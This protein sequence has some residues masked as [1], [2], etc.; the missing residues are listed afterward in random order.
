MVAECILQSDFSYS[1]FCFVL[2]EVCKSFATFQLVWKNSNVLFCRCR[3]I[4]YGI[5][6]NKLTNCHSLALIY[7]RMTVLIFSCRIRNSVV[8]P[9][10]SFVGWSQ[11]GSC[12]E[13]QFLTL[14]TRDQLKKKLRNGFKILQIFYFI[15]TVQGGN[16]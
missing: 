16:S 13:T 7:C 14:R 2:L 6:W 9:E 5:V 10:P 4:T 11:K 3:F 12:S 8:E 1:Y 15:G